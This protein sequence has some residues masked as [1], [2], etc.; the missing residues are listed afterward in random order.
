MRYRLL[1]EL[2]RILKPGGTMAVWPPIFVLP[3]LLL[4]SGLFA[5]DGKRN[6]VYHFRSIEAEN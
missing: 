6:G 1:P 3:H 5:H 2:H 4:G